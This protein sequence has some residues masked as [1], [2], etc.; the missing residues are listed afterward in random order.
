[1]ATL[2]AAAMIGGLAVPRLRRA[3]SR[4]RAAE[5]RLRVERERRY[6]DARRAFD[7]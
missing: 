1:M 6:S 5:H 2:L 7:V 4:M 3:A